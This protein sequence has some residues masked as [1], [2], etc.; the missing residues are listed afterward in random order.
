MKMMKMMK[1]MFQGAPASKVGHGRAMARNPKQLPYFTNLL[2][3]S[4]SL[5]HNLKKDIIAASLGG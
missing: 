5:Q 4:C 2:N 3:Q 1:T